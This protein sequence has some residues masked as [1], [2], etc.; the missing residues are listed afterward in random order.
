MKVLV[1]GATG[2]VGR[3]LVRE[4]LA[5]GDAVT[6]CVRSPEKASELGLSDVLV[7]PEI[8]SETDWS[9]RLEGHDAVVHLAARVHVMRDASAD[10]LAA[11][12]R[13]NRDG[14]RR[15][16]EAAA[17]A[18]VARFVHASSVKAL[19]EAASPDRP[20][21]D[22]TP[23]R[24]SDAYGISKLEAD[25]A[26]ADVAAAGPMT[27]VS[28]RPPLVYGPDVAGNFLSLLAICDRG[29]PLPLGLAR[30]RRSLIFVGNLT[31]AIRHLLASAPG[32][33]GTYLID[34]GEAVPVRRLIRDT[35]AALGRPARL[36]PV[37]PCILSAGLRLLG[38]KAVADRLLA[39]LVVDS[40]R[41]RDDTGWT[42]PYKMV[43]GLAE[44]AAWYRATPRS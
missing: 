23:P 44:T 42:P 4:L 33:S 34:D 25:Q 8:G 3:R 1:T 17:K 38:R 11:F 24:P 19:G 27:V 43:Q 20:M 35:A 32:V 6:A 21:T 14:A 30:N 15:L 40:S 22:A 18:G 29:W 12:R 39:P 28:L 9:G 5:A 2:F 26:L 41:F 37:P 7:V 36:V 16:A 10:P 13:V 31:D